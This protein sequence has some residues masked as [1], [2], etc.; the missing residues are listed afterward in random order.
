MAD[1]SKTAGHFEVSDLLAD[2]HGLR[3]GWNDPSDV[4]AI[5][6]RAVQEI[7]RLRRLL[8]HYG[9]MAGVSE[10]EMREVCKL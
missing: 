2:L 10:E 4:L 7:R 6:D 9:D 1:E 5:A 8:I 3:S